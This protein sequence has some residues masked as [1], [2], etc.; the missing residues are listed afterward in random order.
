MNSDALCL[1]GQ[2]DSSLTSQ[3]WRQE[4]LSI[5]ARLDPYL[6]LS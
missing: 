1:L 6:A 3:L 5:Y 4:D 2:E